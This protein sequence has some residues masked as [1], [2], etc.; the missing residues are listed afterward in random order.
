MEVLFWSFV[1]S[2][3]MLLTVIHSP[4]KWVFGI[5]IGLYVFGASNCSTSTTFNVSLDGHPMSLD[6]TPEPKSADDVV[7]FSEVG[8]SPSVPHALEIHN[9]V[10]PYSEAVKMIEQDMSCLV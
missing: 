2:V 6:C 7:W 3:R 5:G 9:Q 1:S 4:L 10:E 8:L